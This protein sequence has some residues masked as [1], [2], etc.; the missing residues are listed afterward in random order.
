MDVDQREDAAPVSDNPVKQS[1]PVSGEP[2]FSS[3]VPPSGIEA[4][5][6]IVAE[7]SEEADFAKNQEPALDEDD[8]DDEVADEEDVDL[9]GPGTEGA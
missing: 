6:N 9:S 1:P 2:E 7:D 8:S 4:S 5:A 3:D